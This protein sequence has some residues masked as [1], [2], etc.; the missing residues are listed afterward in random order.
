MG[1]IWSINFDLA[2]Q[3]LEFCAMILKSEKLKLC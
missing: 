2:L 1:T 3:F